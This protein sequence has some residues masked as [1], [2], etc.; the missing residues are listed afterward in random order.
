MKKIHTN[1]RLPADLVVS[2][3]PAP[4]DSSAND[5]EQPTNSP[6]YLQAH[7][8]SDEEQTEKLKELLKPAVIARKIKR[9]RKT[10]GAENFRNR[11]S[12]TLMLKSF[13]KAFQRLKYRVGF[14]AGGEEKR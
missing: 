2:M 12:C 6:V 9:L 1:L 13:E 8:V 3:A 7:T 14:D 4:S 11:I 5:S 10:F